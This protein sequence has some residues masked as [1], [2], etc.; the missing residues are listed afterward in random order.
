[1]DRC[2]LR[3]RVV[4]FLSHD[5]SSLLYITL[6]M[7]FIETCFPFRLTFIL[8]LGYWKQLALKCAAV[9]GCSGCSFLRPIIGSIDVGDT[10]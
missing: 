4:S 10:E 3:R 9:A 5:S 2:L 7:A 6:W 8:H 1:M